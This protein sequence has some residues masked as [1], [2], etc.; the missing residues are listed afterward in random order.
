MIREI[1]SS[2]KVFIRDLNIMLARLE[3]GLRGYM[4]VWDSEQKQKEEILNFVVAYDLVV[5]N[6]FFRKNHLITFN[7]GQHSNQI[8]FIL[9]RR[10]RPNFMNYKVIHGKCVVTQYKL[11]VADFRFSDTRPSNEIEAQKSWERSGEIS[12]KM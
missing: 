10:E 8:D 7:S 12:K 6:T 3:G 1:S 9:T 5:A 4:V 11:L 2:E